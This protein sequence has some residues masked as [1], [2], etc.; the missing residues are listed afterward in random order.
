LVERKGVRLRVENCIALIFDLA[1]VWRHFG[2][3]R[4]EIVVQILLVING[5]DS[6]SKAPRSLRCIAVALKW[7]D[8][9]AVAEQKLL[10]ERS[11]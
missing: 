5:R 8:A 10:V 1:V 9:D 11:C 7:A 6:L 3:M 4:D 2:V